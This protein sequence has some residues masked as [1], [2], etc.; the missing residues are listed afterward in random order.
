[1]QQQSTMMNYTYLN[2]G[3][4]IQPN[5]MYY[6]QQPAYPYPQPNQYPMNPMYQSYNMPPQ[7]YNANVQPTVPTKPIQQNQKMNVKFESKPFFPK[8]PSVINIF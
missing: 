3:P 1:M 5:N 4:Q 6:N 8:K 2:K 7:N